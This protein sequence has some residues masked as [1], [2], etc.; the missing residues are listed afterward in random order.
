[1]RDDAGAVVL[2]L[3]LPKILPWAGLTPQMYSKSSRDKKEVTDP[4]E[5]LWS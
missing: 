4:E 3:G 2:N 5:D 1:M